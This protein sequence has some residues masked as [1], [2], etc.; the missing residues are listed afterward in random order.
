MGNKKE[1]AGKQKGD[2]YLP[3]P[4]TRSPLPSSPV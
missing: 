2:G 4:F 3:W 1:A